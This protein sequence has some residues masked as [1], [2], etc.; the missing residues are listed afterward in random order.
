MRLVTSWRRASLLAQLSWIFFFFAALLASAIPVQAGAPKLF[1]ACGPR[2][3]QSVASQERCFDDYLRQELSYFDFVRD[4]HLADLTVVVGRQPAGNGGERVSASL[5]ERKGASETTRATGSF[6]AAPGDS[7]D[8]I[9]QQLGQLVLRMLTAHFMGSPHELEFHVSLK[10][11]DGE[12]LSALADP[13]RYWVLAPEISGEGEGGSGYYFVD[14]TGALTARRITEHN[15]VRLRAAYTRRLSGYKLEDGSRV[16]G[17]VYEAEG[18]AIYAHSV[19]TRG[20]LGLVATGRASEFENLKGH[21]HGGPVAEINVF[22]YQ[23]NATR[24]L[25]AAYQV[26]AWSNWYFERNAAGRGRETRP[27]HALSLV[28]DVNQTWGS[29]QLIG[30]GTQ[31]LDSPRLYRLSVGSLLALRLFEGFAINLKGEASLVRD[32][33]SLRERQITD[34]ELLLWTAQQKTNYMF[35]FELGFAYTF[36]SVHNTIVNPRF[37]RIDLDEE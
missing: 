25:R 21:V 10:R 37:G 24:Q 3:R 7:D 1:L 6:T 19:G 20:A 26:G 31:F 32:Q 18:R 27:Y 33:I 14:L 16:R 8:S 12:T 9:R 5:V 22:P 4:R 28:A 13:W 15:K 11:R 34:L 30:Q 35:E 17:D 2:L 29:V 23:E 36:G